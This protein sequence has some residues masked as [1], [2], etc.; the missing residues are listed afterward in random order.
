MASPLPCPGCILCPSPCPGNGKQVEGDFE[1]LVRDVRVV[2]VLFG[3]V[4]FL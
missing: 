2:R 3:Y 4:R 1:P